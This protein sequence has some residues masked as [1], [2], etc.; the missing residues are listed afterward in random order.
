MLDT[1]APGGWLQVQEMDV[2]TDSSQCTSW[3]NIMTIMGAMFDKLGIGADYAS[4]LGASFEKA[5][6]KNVTA[7]KIKLPAGM[8]M[9]NEADAMNSLIPFKITIPTLKQAMQ[10]KLSE[11]RTEHTRLS[12]NGTMT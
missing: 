11:R 2:K 6:L 9:G 5:G 8:K 10:G 1:L 7:E 3:N 12:A 4:K